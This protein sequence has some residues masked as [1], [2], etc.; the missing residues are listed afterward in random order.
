[1][2]KNAAAALLCAASL[3]TSAAGPRLVIQQTSLA[4]FSHHAAPAVWAR[5]A[6][7]DALRLEAETANPHDAQAVRVFWGE[8]LLG[9]LPR[10]DNGAIARALRAGLPLQAR[11]A[12]RREHPDPRQRIGVEI[13]AVATR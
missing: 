1:M 9:Y 6:E 11:V 4:G 10:R 12:W 3:A 5:L 2:L 13:S 7:G 8:H